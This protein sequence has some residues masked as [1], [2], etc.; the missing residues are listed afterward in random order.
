V[1]ALFAVDPWGLGGVCLRG[2][3]QPARAQWLQ[4]L[5][6]LLPP[7]AVV[8]KA[9][10]N[11]PDGRLLGGLDLAATLQAGR[12]IVER[13]VLAEADGG[14]IL[15]SMA[16]RLSAQ[17]AAR[18]N[19]VLDAGHVRMS[20]EG[21]S[22]DSAARIG[23]VAL[24][25]GMG[26]DEGVPAS[27]LDRMAFLVDLSGFSWRAILV[28]THEPEQ[29]AAARAALAAVQLDGELLQALCATALALGAGSPRVSLLAARAARAAA[30]LDGRA[31]VSEADAVLA[32]RLVLGC[33]ASLAPPRDSVPEGRA[34]EPPEPPPAPESTSPAEPPQAGEGPP[35]AE[36]PP[37]AASPPQAAESAPQLEQI[38]SQALDD[39]VLAA[40]QA[41]IPSGLLARLQAGAGEHGARSGAAGRS[42][43]MRSAGA[44]GRPAGVRAGTPRGNARLNVIET[45]RAAAPWQAL[46]RRHTKDAEQPRAGARIV[47]S[48]EDFRVTRYKQR[49]RTLTIFAVDA[50]GSAALNRLAEAK[51]AV[52]IL[53][54]ECYIRRDEVAVIAFRGK[55]AELL[56]PP[57]RSLVRAK[58]SLA[59]LPGGG[60]TPLATAI[61][62]SAALA[63]R[64][65]R[66]HRQGRRARAAACACQCVDCRARR[67]TLE[68]KILVR[69]HLAAPQ[70][71]GQGHCSADGR[72]LLPAAVRKR[73]E[74]VHPGQGGDAAAAIQGPSMI[75]FK[76]CRSRRTWA[77]SAFCNC[78]ANCVRAARAGASYRIVAATSV[79]RPMRASRNS[80][81][82]LLRT[83]ALSTEV[84]AMALP[85][86]SSMT[87]ASHSRIP[88][89]GVSMTQCD[90]IESRVATLLT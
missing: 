64:W 14:V 38:D 75:C 78:A 39:R 4:L 63:H 61:D 46:R 22:I 67:G 10:F 21:V 31:A 79:P 81:R 57:T 80:T 73:A 11:I 84:Q 43:V 25:E 85:G 34:G 8:R 16:E 41:A 20:R 89:P 15:L 59:G 23:V 1:A 70:C 30:A 82:P 2:A 53:L 90:V 87:I 29:I 58:R 68:D 55:K 71:P 37:P 72:G 51:G 86:T 24:D 26:D 66:Q 76:H 62:A 74:P 28:P 12:A 45:L 50:S 49:A 83:L 60:G 65:E 40:A 17:T 13:G 3:A 56:L 77:F 7:G 33:R 36:P 48:P 19:A 32:G 44:R 6:D 69:R 27:L 9:P 52:E 42:G 47:V 35:A 54:A 88:P 18:L 5:R